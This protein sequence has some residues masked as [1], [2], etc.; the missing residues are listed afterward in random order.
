M[1]RMQD[2]ISHQ[3]ISSTT[4]M[5]Q[6]T[7]A[8]IDVGKFFLDLAILPGTVKLRVRNDEAGGQ[9]VDPTVP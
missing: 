1:S 7:F 9:D 8:G 2:Q 3:S 4:D 6:P 5:P